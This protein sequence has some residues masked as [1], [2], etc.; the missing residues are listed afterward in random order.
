MGNT[1]IGVPIGDIPEKQNI[2]S[3]DLIV[4]ETPSGVRK[5]KPE[6]LKSDVYT[7]E[8]ADNRFIN[9]SQ[10]DLLNDFRVGLLESSTIFKLNGQTVTPTQD[11]GYVDNATGIL[12]APMELK[13]PFLQRS[14]I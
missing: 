13:L 14:E 11:I 4:L 7:K 10:L 8:Q 5:T 1:I 12:I 3:N 9:V 2:E 6:N